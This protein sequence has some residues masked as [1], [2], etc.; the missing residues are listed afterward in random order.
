MFCNL[1]RDPLVGVRY[2][3]VSRR[4]THPSSVWSLCEPEVLDIDPLFPYCE[5]LFEELLWLWLG[6]EDWLLEGCEFEV[7]L[8]D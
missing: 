1:I 7:L 6:V 5:L 2:Q 3:S 8:D 4:V